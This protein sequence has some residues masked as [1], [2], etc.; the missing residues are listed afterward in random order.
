MLVRALCSI[1]CNAKNE[2]KP[3]H[4]EAPRVGKA[5]KGGGKMLSG[6]EYLA[7]VCQRVKLLF[8][9]LQAP[10]EI[11]ASAGGELGGENSR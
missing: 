8:L 10:R 4:W 11:V 6:E 7:S 9:Q 1:G 5:E 2:T 3:I